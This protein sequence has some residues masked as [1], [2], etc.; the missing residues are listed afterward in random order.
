MSPDVVARSET[1]RVLWFDRRVRHFRIG[2]VALPNRADIAQRAPGPPL[3]DY[4]ARLLRIPLKW[5]IH[6]GFGVEPT[7]PGR[8][9]PLTAPL[10]RKGEGPGVRASRIALPWEER[11]GQRVAPESGDRGSTGGRFRR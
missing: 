1:V 6:G 11:W 2:G 5:V 9:L 7:G 4:L 3:R 8:A 10:P